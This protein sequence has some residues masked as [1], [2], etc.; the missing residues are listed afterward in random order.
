[1]ESESKLTRYAACAGCGAK[2]GAGTLA[3]LLQ[4][5]RTRADE[6]L[7]VGYDKSDDACVY[8]LSDSEALVQTVDFFP[9]VADEPYLFGQIAAANALSDIYAMGGE[10][11]LALNLLCLPA[12]LPDEA[13]RE[14]LRGGY[15]KIYEAGAVI[16]GGHTIEGPEPL[17]G[18]CVTGFVNPKSL[19]LN[20][21]ARPGDALLLTKA[22]GIGVATTAAKAGL[23]PPALLERAY[24]QMTTLNKAARDSL[25]AFPVHACTDITGFGLLG[26]GRELAEGSG[27]ALRLQSAAIP[28][29]EGAEELAAMG[30]L[31]AGTYRNREFA[32]A[33]VRAGADIPRER[34]DLLYD[35]QTS[36]GLL[37]ALP[38]DRADEALR[39]VRAHCPDAAIIGYAEEA[40]P[41]ADILVE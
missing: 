29:L 9:P 38:A 25:R 7:L 28:V 14:I 23:A 6:N 11:R 4:G 1:M 32:A 41:E 31:P 20:S 12:G 21:G 19:W 37:F 15:D 34:L 10:P 3:R 13:A 40:C 8:R 2:A 27:C 36:G 39:A 5:F 26:H 17:Y 22:L 30:L 35:P 33:R 18:L 24:R 16:A